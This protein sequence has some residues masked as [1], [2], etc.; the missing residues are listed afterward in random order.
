VIA[1]NPCPCGHLGDARRACTC[2]PSEV[3]RYRSRISAPIRDR[4]DLHLTVGVVPFREL[5][6]AAPSEPSARIRERVVEARC[7]QATRTGRVGVAPIWNSGLGQREIQ[8]W[9]RP[10]SDG[11]LLLEDASDRLSLSSR[12][13]H[14]VLKV[15]RTIADLEGRDGVEEHHV[16][17]ALQYREAEA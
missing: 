13:V 17:E 16:A 6:D 12:G 2:D 10:T 4:I 1:T 9:C 5:H 11:S 15:A 3:A 8:R 14:R 7:R